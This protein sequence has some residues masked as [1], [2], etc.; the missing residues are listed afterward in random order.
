MTILTFATVFKNVSNVVRYIKNG[1]ALRFDSK[2]TRVFK[3]LCL[4]RIF[5]NTWNTE[6]MSDYTD[7][8]IIINFQKKRL[9]G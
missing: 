7:V 3:S 6:E 5:F 1:K 9:V 8:L 4:H 2:S